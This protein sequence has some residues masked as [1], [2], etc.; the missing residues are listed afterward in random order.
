MAFC[1]IFPG[2]YY[3]ILN[4]LKTYVKTPQKVHNALKN[5]G[6]LGVFKPKKAMIT[7]MKFMYFF[8]HGMYVCSC[9]HYDCKTC[10][11]HVS[12][13]RNLDHLITYRIYDLVLIK[14]NPSVHL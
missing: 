6:C 5:V 10:T 3:K 2:I 11:L 13:E 8:L 9:M 7:Y 12:T 14:L 1:G 4:T